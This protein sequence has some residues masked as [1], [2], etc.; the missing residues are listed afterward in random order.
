VKV[1]Q[2][3]LITPGALRHANVSLQLH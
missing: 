2:A 3:E 1:A